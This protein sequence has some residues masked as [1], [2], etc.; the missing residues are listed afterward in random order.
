MIQQDSPNSLNPTKKI[1]A[2]RLNK[3]KN[4]SRSIKEKDQVAK[5]IN[6]ILSNNTCDLLYDQFKQQE[7]ENYILANYSYNRQ[8]MFRE[9]YY[10]WLMLE[11]LKLSDTGLKQL[12]DPSE[13]FM[14]LQQ[15]VD[16]YTKKINDEK[17]ILS[18]D[19]FT[20]ILFFTLK[21]CKYEEFLKFNNEVKSLEQQSQASIQTIQVL[22]KLNFVKKTQKF[23]KICELFIKCF[24]SLEIS[25]QFL[26]EQIISKSVIED[27]INQILE[28][29]IIPNKKDV[30]Q[31]IFNQFLS[32]IV[33]DQG[34]IKE[35]IVNIQFQLIQN[36]QQIDN[37]QQYFILMDYLEEIILFYVLCLNSFDDYKEV[38]QFIQRINYQDEY[39]KLSDIYKYS[40][41]KFQ[42]V[43][44]HIISI[45]DL[46]ILCHFW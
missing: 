11:Q 39:Y 36:Y 25:S 46:L 12:D 26:K 20:L 3:K 19:A 34:N 18:D 16:Q 43:V 7:F 30:K 23:Q 10:N 28:E 38:E 35:Q 27:Q 44:A 32:K 9:L 13:F 17:K 42:E 33:W 15:L 1:K 40:T 31:T 29:Q 24:Q 45:Q 21:Y 6:E 37:S 41:N 2:N 14:S 4:N 8:N 5:L 22:K